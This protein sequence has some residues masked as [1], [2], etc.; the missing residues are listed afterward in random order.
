MDYMNSKKINF[1]VARSESFTTEELEK[2]KEFTSTHKT[3]SSA[4]QSLKIDRTVLTNIL[5]KGSAH[6]TT[7]SKVRKSLKQIATTA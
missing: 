4:A 7:V 2:L 1:R 5:L 6:P 3:T